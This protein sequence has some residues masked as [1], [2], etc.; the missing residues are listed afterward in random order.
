MVP[1]DIGIVIDLPS[2]G[3]VTKETPKHRFNNARPMSGVT[4]KDRF[5]LTILRKKERLL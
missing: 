5:N 2:K 3:M 1:T 4:V